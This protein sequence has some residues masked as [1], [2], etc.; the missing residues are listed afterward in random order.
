METKPLH[1]VIET[2][3]FVARARKLLPE[4]EVKELV[5]AI[6]ADPLQGEVMEGTGGARKMRWARP[7][8]GKRGGCRVVYFHHGADVPIFLLDI[9]GKNEKANLSKAERN[10]LAKIL[11]RIVDAYR[12]GVREHVESR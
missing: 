9:Y 4:P 2:P 8:T 3:L 10:E 5:N 6:A 7:G 12:E 1:A 11:A